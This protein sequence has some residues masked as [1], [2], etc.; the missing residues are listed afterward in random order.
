[1]AANI[2]PTTRQ[3]AIRLV[4]QR[5]DALQLKRY[6]RTTETGPQDLTEALAWAYEFPDVSLRDLAEAS[7]RSYGTVQRWL[8]KSGVQLR[9]R[10]GPRRTPVTTRKGQA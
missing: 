3:A 5:A 9:G 8:R 1:V 7:R 10:G 4:R 2:K 6:A